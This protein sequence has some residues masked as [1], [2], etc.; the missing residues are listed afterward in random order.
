[1]AFG[2]G[3]AACHP[4]PKSIVVGA[5]FASAK[6]AEGF[7]S[8]VEIDPKPLAQ[9]AEINPEQSSD[10]FWSVARSNSQDAGET[11]VDTPIKRLLASSFD[12][13]PLLGTQDKRFHG[14]SAYPIG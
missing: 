7:K 8:V 5:W 11:L 2:T 1:V 10:V 4:F 13:P 12:F 3:R 14:L 9:L 6:G